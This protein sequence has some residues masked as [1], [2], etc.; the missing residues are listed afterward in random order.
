MFRFQQVQ[1]DFITNSPVGPLFVVISTPVLQ[2]FGCIRKA[3]KPVGIQTLSP[4]PP[5]ECLDERIVGRLSRPLEVQRDAILL[6]PKIH[7]TG[8]EF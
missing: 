3:Q 2:L 6:G 7:V 4:E 5:A 1:R 8:D